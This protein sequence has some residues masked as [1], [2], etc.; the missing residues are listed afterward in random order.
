MPESKFYELEGDDQGLVWFA[1]FSNRQPVP[2]CK[3]HRLVLIQDPM[4]FRQLKCPEDNKIFRLRNNL[5]QDKELAR[6]KIFHKAVEELEL[7]RIDPEGYQVV[8]KETVKNDPAFWIE[9]KLSNTSRGLQLMIQA[10]KR[11]QS[12]KKVQ[13]FVEPA[14]KRMDFDRNGNDIHPSGMFTRVTAEFK[15]TKS[16]ISKK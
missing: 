3:K 8:A 14:S 4:S 16:E 12:G 6:Q 9:A 2:Y 7:V 15:D 1:Q 5:P 10:G 11:D 13:L